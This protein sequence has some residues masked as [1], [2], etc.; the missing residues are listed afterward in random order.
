MSQL[1]PG[2]RQPMDEL[3]FTPRVAGK[4]GRD[5]DEPEEA[6]VGKRVKTIVTREGVLSVMDA[7]GQEVR[8]L[9]SKLA[10]IQSICEDEAVSSELE[11]L[12]GN[13]GM[14]T[15]HTE[16]LDDLLTRYTEAFVFDDLALRDIADLIRQETQDALENHTKQIKKEVLQVFEQAIIPQLAEAVK[17]DVSD[18]IMQKVEVLKEELHQ[19]YKESTAPPLRPPAE[20]SER[21]T[22][23]FSTP[24]QV[25]QQVDEAPWSEVVKCRR[26]KSKPNVKQTPVQ[27]RKKAA[28]TDRPR[29]DPEGWK[30][31]RECCIIIEQAGM[32]PE[33]IVTRLKGEM[34]PNRDGM[35]IQ[36]MRHTIKDGVIITATNKD[37]A[38]KV[39]EM[40]K[41]VFPNA[42]I[43]QPTGWTPRIL[44]RDIPE[45]QNKDSLQNELNECNADLL[46]PGDL[47]PMHTLGRPRQGKR[48]WVCQVKPVI[49]CKLL[50]VGKLKLDWQIVPLKEF[51][52]VKQCFK[53]QR[54]GHLAASCKNEEA[55]GICAG[56]HD[57]RKC[58]KVEQEKCVNCGR[59][60]GPDGHSATSRR[61]P[62]RQNEREWVAQMTVY[63]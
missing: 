62:V 46:Q 40:V 63:A 19:A 59:K 13:M 48:S 47:V 29:G 16:T 54:Y 52:D 42:E 53:C 12:R 9:K 17:G 36:G 8:S 51:Q 31:N 18:A 20:N 37:A 24:Q 39:T 5:K 32:K 45:Q 56:P 21:A 35:T 6:K 26:A 10:A 2:Q 58:T 28:P 25:E 3:F 60:G 1:S 57:T 7:L 14:V 27:D 23:G 44:I 41:K 15:N 61:C 34:R 38:V 49:L 43:K 33:D 50:E 55:C 22:I 30:N 4:R 11:L